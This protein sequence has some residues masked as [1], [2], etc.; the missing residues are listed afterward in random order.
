M[1]SQ[2]VSNP[3][4]AGY[5]HASS[6]DS[7]PA[8]SP[9]YPT[10]HSAAAA[11]RLAGSPH[12]HTRARPQHRD[13]QTARETP[14]PS[15]SAPPPESPSSA[16]RSAKHPAASPPPRAEPPHPAPAYRQYSPHPPAPSP[17]S[18]PSATPGSHLSADASN[19][20]RNKPHHKPCE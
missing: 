19:S 5:S 11:S 18:P 1:T 4:K 6:L 12:P 8:S 2:I 3:L 16:P 14:P 20:S 9:A 7:S 10:P 13:S 17:Q 15:R